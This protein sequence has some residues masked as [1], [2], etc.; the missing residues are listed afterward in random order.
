MAVEMMAASQV[1]LLAI[2]NRLQR[3]FAHLELGTPEF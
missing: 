2:Q 3:G 1:L